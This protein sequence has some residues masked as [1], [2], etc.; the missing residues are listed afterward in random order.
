MIYRITPQKD[1]TI[2]ERSTNLDR[3]LQNT[4]LDSI[5]ELIREKHSIAINGAFSS[6]VLIQFDIGQLSGYSTLYNRQFWLKLY[7]AEYSSFNSNVDICVHE[8]LEDWDNGIG[9]FN[10]SPLTT[11]GA[12]WENRIDD[13]VWTSGS[14]GTFDSSSCSVHENIGRFDE[15]DDDL[16]VNVTDICESW[17]SGTSDNHGFMVKHTQSAEE[18]E[19]FTADLKWFSAETNTIYQPKLEVKWDDIVIWYFF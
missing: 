2:Y 8:V 18:N 11:N 3:T 14:G 7:K 1:T 4:G 9:T 17:I 15:E 19:N 16:Y 12:S 13:T 10:D 5:L 6:R